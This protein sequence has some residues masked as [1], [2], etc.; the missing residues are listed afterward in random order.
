MFKRDVRLKHYATSNSF[1]ADDEMSIF[2][3]MN[4]KWQLPKAIGPRED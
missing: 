4:D 1:D 2:C 3:R